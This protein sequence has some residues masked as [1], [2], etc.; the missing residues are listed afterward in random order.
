MSLNELAHQPKAIAPQPRLQI[1][2]RRVCGYNLQA[3]MLIEIGTVEKL[4]RYPVKSMRGEARESA[5]LGWHGVEGDRRFALRKI[6]D[7][8]G[9]PWLTASRFAELLLYTPRNA[10]EDGTIT[11]VQTPDGHELPLFAPELAAD[12]ASRHG[13]P[14]EMLHM[15]H[16][17]FD[18]AAVSVIALE[19]IAE[20]ARLAAVPADIRRFRPNVAL[21]L[22]NPAAFQEDAWLG[23]TLVFGEAVAAPAVSVTMPD[24]RC[25]VINVDPDTA[26]IT[27]EVL[28]TVVRLNQNR[29]GIYGT[30]VR[31]GEISAGQKVFLRRDV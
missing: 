20:I 13:T 18:D 2:L 4:Y 23:G 15:R 31:T 17:I 6:E 11:H 25:A 24:I 10:S 9:F 28:K 8:S 21:R 3:H 14:V 16:G 1:A 27:P 7:H 22:A 26:A 30:V 5:T 12:V 19:T 29:A